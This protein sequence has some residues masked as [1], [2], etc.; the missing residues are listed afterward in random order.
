MK[1]LI[2]IMCGL[3]FALL[4]ASCT[5][6]RGR[7]ARRR[8]HE[9]MERCI[10]KSRAV[11]AYRNSNRFP[12]E[13]EF[14]KQNLLVKQ[15]PNMPL[16]LCEKASFDLLSGN[17]Q[18][19]EQGLSKAVE[20]LEGF[21]DKEKEKSAA[22]V[23]GNESD[24]VFKGE[25]YER[26]T[27]YM[28]YGMCLLEKNDV[29]NALACFRRAMLM[30]GDTELNKHQSDFGILF[31]LAAKCYDLRGEPAQRDDMLRYALQ[32]YLNRND[33]AVNSFGNSRR[34][35]L[36]E[37][38]DAIN[39]KELSPYLST[40]LS[41]AD[42]DSPDLNFLPEK[43]KQELKKLVPS[44]PDLGFNCMVVIWNGRGPA[45][46]QTGEYLSERRL[47]V[48]GV[49][50]FQGK[51]YQYVIVQE[52]GNSTPCLDILGDVSY[53]AETRGGR[54]MDKIQK[55]KKN[56][57]NAMN[58]TSDVLQSE[59][60]MHIPYIGLISMFLGGAMDDASKEMEIGADV[61]SWQCLPSE[62]TIALL[63][64]PAGQN[65]Y[66]FESYQGDKKVRTGLPGTVEIKAD[67]NVR[68]IHVF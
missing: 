54:M 62:F 26:A 39:K 36:R 55:S 63:K 51:P 25:P 41:W 29:D 10:D 12:A 5:T 6:T 3:V 21:F 56:T 18:A 23:W 60:L 9:H 35:F 27:L 1:R 67:Q 43:T 20:L 68:F 15:H 42:W 14:I 28:L 40:L 7:D 22:S 46:Y 47:D 58:T 17:A 38:Q 31:L 30:D 34:R 19:A 2:F 44:E 66:Q 33:Q 61:R 52:N 53:Q 65:K 37:V 4:L 32:A 48:R 24:K 57:K 16:Y 50:A 45:F 59:F 8:E 13:S 11:F 49:S 64:L